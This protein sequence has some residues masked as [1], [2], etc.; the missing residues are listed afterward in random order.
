MIQE[1]NENNFDNNI[2]NG[3]KLVVF[4]AD[5]CGFC[6]KQ[7]KI[8]SELSENNIWIGE[9]NSDK[10]PKLIEKFEIQGFPAFIL[11]KDGKILTKFLGFREKFDLMDELLK[12]L[13]I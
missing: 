1:L 2:K 12:H 6:K 13:K 8:L 5:W 7:K 4:T 11:F 3:I 9:V 10:N